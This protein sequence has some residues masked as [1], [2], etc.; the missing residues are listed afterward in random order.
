MTRQSFLRGRAITSFLKM[1]RAV[2]LRNLETAFPRHMAWSHALASRARNAAFIFAVFFLL[3]GT[4]FAQQPS[5]DIQVASGAPVLTMPFDLKVIVHNPQGERVSLDLPASTTDTFV[6]ARAQEV[7]QKDGNPLDQNFLLKILPLNVGP[8]S[9]KLFWKLNT[10]SGSTEI[11]SPPFILNVADKPL[12]TLK[13]Y[14]I[15]SPMK[16]WPLLW[17]WI[18]GALI[19]ALIIWAY[20]KRKKDVLIGPSILTVDAR[21][22]HV[23]AQEEIEKLRSAKLFE[24][25]RYK[26]FYFELS[27]ILKRYFERRFPMPATKMT[28]V[29]LYRHLKQSEIDP[30]TLSRFKNLFDRADLVKFAKVSPEKN[31]DSLDIEG[32]LY[33]VQI[34]KPKEPLPSQGQGVPR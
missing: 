6:I 21:P 14:D 27:E 24:E 19:I 7:S 18:L 31:W 33:L 20:L 16:A 9:I 15:A 23:I 34:T 28:T 10:P 5:F 13:I 29:E 8:V 1:L 30:Q 4:A 22:A 17:P 3:S 2:F 26:E 25:A 11:Q 32:A 12:K